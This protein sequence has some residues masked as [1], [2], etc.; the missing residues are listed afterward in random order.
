MV[1][2]PKNR[3]QA[4]G[5][6]ERDVAQLAEDVAEVCPHDVW[7]QVSGWSVTRIV[8][9]LIVASACVRLDEP[10]RRQAARAVEGMS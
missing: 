9:A 3:F 8:S 7:R 6:A 1:P 10:I 5:Q 2:L 4:A